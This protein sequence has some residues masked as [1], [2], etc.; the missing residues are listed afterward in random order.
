MIG[1][2]RDTIQVMRDGQNKH[3]ALA[4]FD[5]RREI[6]KDHPHLSESQ[7]A[8][9]EQILASRDQVTALEGVA[10]SGKTTS[11][12]A[13]REAA[14]REGYKVEGFAPTSRAAQKL[15]EAGIESSTLQRHLARSDR[16]A[17]RTKAALRSRRI[18]SGEHE[19]DERV[20]ASTKGQ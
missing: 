14:E 20:P 13:V 4:S 15:G 6:E 9:V 2:E 1:Y 5:T 7:R 12:A 3:G 10:G 17:R 16:A 19:A 11:L 8:A 18:E